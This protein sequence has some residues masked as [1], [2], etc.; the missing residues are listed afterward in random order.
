MAIATI[1]PATG[2]TIQTFEALDSAQ[3]EAKL[4]RAS[5]A[6][7]SWRKASS[8]IRA[9]HAEA[10][11]GLFEERVDEL[12]L[13]MALEMG[14]P[15][16]AGREE[17]L[18][19][20]NGAR[21]YARNAQAFLKDA[22]HEIEGASVFTRWQP[23]GAVLAIMPWNFPFWQAMR[24]A[25]PALMAGNVALLKH[26][27]NVPQCALMMEKLHREAGFPDGVFQTLLIGS[28]A[29]KEII[30]DG[31]I[32]AVTVTGSTEAG[33]SVAAAAGKAVKKSVLELGGS[34]PFI[35]MPSAGMEQAVR[36]GVKA[37]A[38]NS[39]QSCIAAKRFLVH[40]AVYEPFVSAFVQAMSALRIGDPMDEETEVG[41][42]ATAEILESLHS[43][44][45]RAIESGAQLLTGGR[46]IGAAGNFYAPTAL[47]CLRRDAAVASEETFGPVAF[48]FR[49]RSVDEAV[50]LANATSFG[51]GAS[52]WTADDAERNRF[53]D[54]IEAGQVFVNAMVASDPRAPFGGVK[55]SGYGRELSAAG[56]REFVNAKTV[57][58]NKQ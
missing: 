51:L 52:V 50:D 46:R 8:A 5:A 37:R 13:L 40:A 14:K 1:N 10:L 28:S 56:I 26:A 57:W 32:A 49:I 15:I 33:R 48:I 25:A 3:I 21:F 17:A 58:I 7:R 23:L 24:F 6:F 35:V 27:S 16:R 29:V 43:Q 45:T 22:S 19:C 18:K 36:T 55:G 30:S 41:P 44:V 20:A 38:V 47:D 4:D 9:K 42:L 31:R 12:A 34:D 2:V 11:A 53:I 54:E 39:G